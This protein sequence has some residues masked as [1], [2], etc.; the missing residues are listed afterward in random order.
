MRK[1]LTM[2]A[3]LLGLAVGCS[4][5]GTGT[6]SSGSG[7][8]AGSSSSGGAGGTTSAGGAGGTT[9]GGSTGTGGSSGGSSGSNP[10]DGTWKLTA[11]TCN[12]QAA[13]TAVATYFTSPDSTTE[14][15]TGNTMVQT[16]DLGGCNLIYDWAA[17]I[18]ATTIA[19]SPTGSSCSP[20]ACSA[21]CGLNAPADSYTYSVSGST[22]TATSMASDADNTCTSGGMSNPIVYTLTKE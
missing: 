22:L 21:A 5:G 7:G 14:A 9:S 3:V 11:I 2:C 16:I 15:F 18:T 1:M 8:S 6:S 13:N 10:L 19:L 17:L 12:G 4:G 20:T